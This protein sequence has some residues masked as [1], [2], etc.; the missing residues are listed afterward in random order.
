MPDEPSADRV[1]EIAVGASQER[2]DAA[3][4]LAE[5]VRLGQVV[6]R[7]ELEP[8]HLVELIVA[9]GQDQDRAFEPADRRRRSTSKPSISGRRTSRTMRSGA[10]FVATER[11]SVPVR[12]TTTS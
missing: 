3:E 7:A 12:A 9:C 8:D 5:A 4:E 1:G 11:P 6:V 2:L 10:W